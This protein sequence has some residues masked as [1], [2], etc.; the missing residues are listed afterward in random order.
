MNF[1]RQSD[2]LA[3]QWSRGNRD[4]ELM[5]S[6]ELGRWALPIALEHGGHQ[7]WCNGY[8]A[9][10]RV[11]TFR[12]LCTAIHFSWDHSFESESPVRTT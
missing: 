7:G 11:S 2:M 1:E 8:T 10:C 9:I 6:L 12:L 5:L 4:F 3:W